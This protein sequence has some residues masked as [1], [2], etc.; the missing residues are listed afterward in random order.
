MCLPNSFVKFSNCLG[1]PVLGFEKEISFLLRK[2]EAKK[3]H[4]VK[5]SGEGKNPC[6]LQVLRRKFEGSSA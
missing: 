6:P 5:V 2:L 3:G 1:L 4:G